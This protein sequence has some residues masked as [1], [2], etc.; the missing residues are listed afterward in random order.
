MFPIFGSPPVHLICFPIHISF[1][2]IT[3]TL[4]YLLFPAFPSVMPVPPVLLISKNPGHTSDP[5]GLSLYVHNTFWTW[6][7]LCSLIQTLSYINSTTPVCYLSSNL[8]LSSTSSSLSIVLLSPLLAPRLG[9]SSLSSLSDFCLTNEVISDL[10]PLTLLWGLHW[11]R[12]HNP[13][14]RQGDKSW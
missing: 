9:T 12:S 8:N 2:S 1:S 5:S 3:L 4:P 11:W 10:R 7:V 14:D 6:K 13:K